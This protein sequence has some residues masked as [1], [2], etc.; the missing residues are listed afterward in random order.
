M[1][2][3]T[4]SGD[5]TASREGPREESVPRTV[6]SDLEGLRLHA[7]SAKSCA[8]RLLVEAVRAQPFAATAAA[9]GVGFLLGG[10]IPRGAMVL[11]V[12]TVTRVAA[13]WLSEEILTQ[14]GA[15]S[16]DSAAEGPR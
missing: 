3:A 12:G 6:R 10:G 4:A 13:A 11:L 2:A 15:G 14:R 7:A 8:E 1:A 5:A 16:A 9:A